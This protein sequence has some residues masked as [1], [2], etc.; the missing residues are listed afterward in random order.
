[1]LP[2]CLDHSE[3]MLNRL[4]PLAHFF[5]ML[6]EP[7][8]NGLESLLMLPTRDPSLLAGGAAG[9]DG[10]ALAGA[11]PV[12][13]QNQ[14][15]FL[16][17][18][19]MGEPFTGRTDVDI[20]LSHVAKVLLAKAAFGFC[21]RGH[22]FGQSDRDACLL[23]RQNLG[24]VEI[25]AV[26]DDI[27]VLRLQRVFRPLGHAG[28]LRTVIADVGHLMRDDQMMLGIDGYLNVV[29]DDA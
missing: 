10:A 12:A 4:T 16:V 15:V 9:F 26:R 2:S 21:P 27:E 28:E 25:A 1:M 7:P 29:A 14:P 24:A 18:V 20:F 13:M 19:M 23:A 11:G 22:R 17:R 6:V 8:L 3:R 5:R